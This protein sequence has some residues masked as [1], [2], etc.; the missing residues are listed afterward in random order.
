MTAGLK[1]PGG[2]KSDQTEN[3]MTRSIANTPIDLLASFVSGLTF[4]EIPADVIEKAKIHIGDTLAAGLAGSRSN[5]FLIARKTIQGSGPVRIWG[6]HQTAGAR[7]AALVNGV[8]AHAFELDDSGGCDHS[9]AV[10]LPAVLA[11]VGSCDHPISGREI[12]AAVVAGYDVGRRILEAT[13]GYDA[14]NRLGWHS[15]GTCGT[16]AAAA[17][18]ARLRKLDPLAT[19]DAITLSTS[20]SSGLWAFIHD[21]SQAKKVH[22]GR[23]AEGGL[24]AAMLASE[25]MAGPSKVFD[26]VWGGFFRTFNKDACQPALLSEDLG[27]NWKV[28][29]AVLKP[30]ASCRGAHSAIDALEDILA[31]TGAGIDDIASMQLDMSAML[32]GMCGAR[33]H[34]AMAATQ[35][36]LPYAL[37][38]RCTFGTAGLQAYSTD[39]RSDARIVE[40]M[41]TIELRT[42]ETMAPMAEPV[43]TTMF[44]DGRRFS[45]MVPRATGSAERPMSQGAIRAKFDELAAMGLTEQKAD[46]LW[47]TLQALEDLDDGRAIETLLAGETDS[48]PLFR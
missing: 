30:Y 32:M 6:T 21:G 2:G 12:L 37:A 34:G 16:L 1:L 3:T 14:H 35:M 17:A 47:S 20:F 45:R 5:E 27:K 11:A 9:G 36:S 18:V 13:G 29:R 26:D 44:R 28:R 46:D 31:E 23:A 24:L 7:D 22:A 38:A 8:A 41:Q 39:R 48:R 43:L 40:R 25:G 4:E 15:T 19:R 42:D 33:E 10:V